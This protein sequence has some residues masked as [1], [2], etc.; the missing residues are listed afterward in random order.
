MS[1]ENLRDSTVDQVS[2]SDIGNEVIVIA[3][4]QMAAVDS[5]AFA[6]YAA[7]CRSSTRHDLRHGRVTGQQWMFAVDALASA[8][9]TQIRAEAA[10]MPMQLARSS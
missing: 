5:L 2:T 6:F 8:W 4:I 3:N 7:A 1:T 10:F 9:S